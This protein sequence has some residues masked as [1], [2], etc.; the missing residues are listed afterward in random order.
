[1]G[2]QQLEEPAQE[3]ITLAQAKNHLRLDNGLTADDDLIQL[4]I[5]TAR[6]EAEAL[7]DRSF[8]TQR[9][10]LTLDGF[11]R[12]EN[13]CTIELDRGLVQSV[14]RIGY[15]DMARQL[16]AIDLTPGATIVATDF[17]RL[18]ARLTPIFGEV[19]P[20]AIPE[21]G[22]VEI[23]YTAGY[24]DDPDDVPAGIRQWILMRVATMYDHRE[25]VELVARGK[26]E[27]IPFVNGL[28]DP[29][30]APQI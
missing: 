21:I 22:V 19:W 3:P 10:R 4:L 8:I 29:Y 11:Y 1:M 17:S 30:R 26:I 15:L 16:Q 25:E 27:Q 7:T 5:S 6:R 24:G 23:D 20:I 28:L 9:W 2:L 18:P 13:P 14:D 12:R